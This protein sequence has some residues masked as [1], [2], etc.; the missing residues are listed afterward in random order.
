MAVRPRHV[1]CLLGT[2]QD[3]D[4]V[5]TI[6]KAHAPGFVF[7]DEY[8][9]SAPD[10]RMK[11]AFEVSADRVTPSFG[12][13]D[14]RAIAEHR[15]VVYVLSPHL[16][17]ATAAGTSASMLALVGKLIAAGATAVKSESAGIAHGL[18]RWKAL[19]AAA[20]SEDVYE[21]AT[22][23]TEAWV[24]RPLEDDARELFYSCGM[25]L[26]GEPDVEVPSSMNPG[27]AITWIDALAMYLVA[28]KPE[29]GLRDGEGFRPTEDHPRRVL[30][31][32]ECERYEEDDFFHNPY[33]Y[34][35]LAE[36]KA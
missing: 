25:H 5:E 28:E 8:S 22:A 9:A 11:R 16:E 35:N 12:D 6:V 21:R 34:W 17:P 31:H 10:P 27:E 2:W 33:G 4:A 3:F 36:L 30:R 7:D 32:L 23:L 18:G 29:G 19:A 1:V 13:D 15:A 14:R 24:R 20:T 26:L